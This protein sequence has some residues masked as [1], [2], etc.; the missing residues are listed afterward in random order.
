MA[1]SVVAAAAELAYAELYCLSNFSFQR[2]ASHPEELVEQ[3]AG[4]GYR[5]LA[6]TDE[7]SMAGVVRAH[8]RAKELNLKLLIG[9][10]FV[11][12]DG[13][14]LL[15]LARSQTGYSALCAL[16]TRARRRAGKGSYQIDLGEITAAPPPECIGILAPPYIDEVAGSFPDHAL[17]QGFADSF[18]DHGFLGVA[19]HCRGRD[20]AHLQALLAAAKTHG[21]A[22]VACGAV[23]MH[24]RSR[25]ALQDVLVCI[26][27][28]ESLERA[29]MALFPNGER[30]LRPLEKLTRCYPPELLAESVRIA[31]LC[32]FSLDQLAYEYPHELVPEG[33]SPGSHLA[34]LTWAG[35]RRRWPAGI[36]PEVRCQ[37]EQELQLIG[38]LAYEHF[39]LTVEDLVRFARS[40][41]I[42]CQGR[43]S[44]ANSAV[45]FC[46]GI[47]EVDPARMSMLFERFISKE[48]NEP[49]DI[50][51]DFE[52]QRRE[53]VIQY[54]YRKYGRERAAL[55]ASVTTYR[56]RSAIRDLGRALGLEPAQL[57]ALSRSMAWWDGRDMI[58]ERLREMG[59]DPSGPLMRR[60]V[61][62]LG[63]LVR[64]PRHL[65][66]HV[67]GFVISHHPLSTL[68]P[69]ENSAMAERTVIQWDKDDLEAL[70]LLKVDVLALGMLSAI[71]R[72]FELIKGFDGRQ[73]DMAA[74]PAEDPAT[75][76]MMQQGDT[77]GVFQ[78]ESR[79][80]MAML[81]RLKPACFYDLVIQIAIVRPGPIQ[82]GMVNPYLRRRQGL[83]PVNYLRPELE[84]V[85]KRTLGVPV[86]QEQVMQLAMV[87]AGFTAGE[88][89]QLRRSM[90][91]WKRLGSVT[92]FRD[93]LI[94][95]MLARGYEQ[96]FAEAVFRQIEGFGAYGFPESHSASF[97]LLAYASAWLKRHEPE[98][99]TC[100]LLNSQP[101]GFYSASDLVQDARRHEVEVLPVEVNRSSW[102]HSLVPISGIEA[103]GRPA[104][105]L[106][107]R[108]VRG[109]SRSG[110][111]RLL[112]ARERGL[113]VQLSDLLQRSGINRKDQAA[114]ANAGALDELCENRHQ[115]HWALL[116]ESV[117][118]AD[119]LTDCQPA[120]TSGQV[121]PPAEGE[122]LVAD[123]QSIGLSLGR[124]PLALLRNRLNALRT[125][126][127]SDWK[128]RGDGRWARLAGLVKQRQRPGSA[129]GVVFMTLEDETGMINLIV[130]AQIVERYR[131]AILAGQLLV[132]NGVTQQH[133]G[134][135]HL[136]ARQ[137]EDHSELLGRLPTVSR[138]FH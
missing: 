61:W 46:L 26:G 67:G 56:T 47:T 34:A 110:A 124:H 72:C 65:S 76:R 36:Q 51:V 40:Q 119:L 112:A 107:L 38:E 52:H 78:I 8:I 134:V 63:Q 100:A 94:D 104:I 122:V 123:Y 27:R 10:E 114:L 57:D 43:G 66:Q 92:R 62:L 126:T 25:R 74:I 84:E 128:N 99:F 41:G 16:I 60:F 127:A 2:G 45:C 105:R 30:H 24:Q 22:A 59:I 95:G 9:A 35:A 90:A 116:D 131:Q 98:A 5:A 11:C 18:G 83:E 48:R 96:G 82:G 13:Y 42:L 125:I 7:C 49:P 37:I 101:L 113:F 1:E 79:A 130:W 97:A 75:Y 14:V 19:L 44:A 73:L 93:K 80:Q 68:V 55:A 87:A 137:I 21:V 81:P 136:I 91:A 109:L 88:A 70:G 118:T 54:L 117:V 106:G 129:K 23:H 64:F 86:F 17:I 12:A 115:T 108:L 32:D 31:E 138:D 133:A 33:E 103:S 58:P 3:A 77:I 15:L 135:T 71:R 39:F 85:L 6:I 121:R 20:Q 132:V 102:D 89:D 53:E 111:D 29:G 4:L 28:G 50:D 69:V 120:V